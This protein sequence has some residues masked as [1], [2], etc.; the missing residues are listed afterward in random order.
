MKYLYLLGAVFL[1]G[2]MMAL[3]KVETPNTL[4]FLTV[5]ICPENDSLT[6]AEVR[7]Y[8]KTS[9]DI[10]Q[11]QN[12]LKAEK[13]GGH[14]VIQEFY[15]KRK[16]LIENVNWAEEKFENIEDRI[17][18]VKSAIKMEGNLKSKAELDAEIAEIKQNPYYT[19]EQK[20]QVIALM[21]NHRNDI[22]ESYIAP[23]KPDW[24]A[25]LAYQTELEH[26]TDFAAQNR[27]DPP[28]ID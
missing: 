25:V 9:I 18:A 5:E 8:I 20:S 23:T 15:E 16:T 3:P 10:T 19:S 14:D 27:S 21:R 28:K 12:R 6:K 2:N 11:L 13:G 24:P 1:W 17:F 7:K 26:L 22:I 4:N